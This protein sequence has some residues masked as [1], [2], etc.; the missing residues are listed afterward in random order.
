MTEHSSETQAHPA[1][2]ADSVCTVETEIEITPAMIEAGR[3]AFCDF[4]SR[5]EDVEDA[6]REIYWA[7]AAAA[8]KEVKR[9]ST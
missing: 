5:F 4:D 7:M 6:V 9:A 1:A 3:S 8:I 2:C